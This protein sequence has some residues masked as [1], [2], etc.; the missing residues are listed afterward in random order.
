MAEGDKINGRAFPMDSCGTL[1]EDRVKILD[2]DELVSKEF[3]SL[4][5][6][7]LLHVWLFP[8]IILMSN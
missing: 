8:A 2:E 5:Y 6:F 4:V 7:K 1:G 3:F